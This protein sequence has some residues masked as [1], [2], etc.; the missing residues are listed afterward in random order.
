MCLP[1]PTPFTALHEH[2]INVGSAHN[3]DP[4]YA[5]MLFIDP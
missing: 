2:A 3:A 1:R 4:G 5:A